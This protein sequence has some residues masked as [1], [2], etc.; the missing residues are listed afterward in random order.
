[1]EIGPSLDAVAG[2]VEQR[3]ERRD[4]V[5]PETEDA[6]ILILEIDATKSCYNLVQ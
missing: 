4:D 2:L 6:V 1:M 5:D 3:T